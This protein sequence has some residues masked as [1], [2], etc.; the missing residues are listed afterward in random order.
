MKTERL[1][2]LA[3]GVALSRIE[4]TQNFRLGAVGIR[5]RDGVLVS[6]YNELAP[7]PTWQVH[8]EARL[9]MKLTPGSV[10]AVVRLLA[11]GNWAM[12]KCCHSC[13][14]LLRRKG[15]KT[16]H[17]SIAPNEFGT[18]HLMD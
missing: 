9:C 13:E 1:L 15:V 5:G 11:N 14:R 12:A 16:V 6:G 10:V 17:Y 18:L 2:D 3:A 7:E 8:A 4:R